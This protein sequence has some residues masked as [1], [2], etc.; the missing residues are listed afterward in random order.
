MS[1]IKSGFV[2]GVLLSDH[3]YFG[4]VLTLNLGID[5]G[6]AIYVSSNYTVDLALLSVPYIKTKVSGIPLKVSNEIN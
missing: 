2:C 6:V 5:D 4:K 3:H 1:K